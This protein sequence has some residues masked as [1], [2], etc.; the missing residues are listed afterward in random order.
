MPRA[1]TPPEPHDTRR[2]AAH[3]TVG[4]TRTHHDTLADA[5]MIFWNSPRMDS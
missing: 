3:D 4:A 2:A 1:R 5:T